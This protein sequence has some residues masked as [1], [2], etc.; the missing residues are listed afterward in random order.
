VSV[1]QPE[2]V[3]RRVLWYSAGLGVV[4]LLA[5]CAFFALRHRTPPLWLLRQRAVSTTIS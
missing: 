4:I 5:L 2:I 3:G 1:S